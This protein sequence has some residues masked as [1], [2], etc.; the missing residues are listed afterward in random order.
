MHEMRPWADSVLEP[1]EVF[2]VRRWGAI[3]D[4]SSLIT[5]LLHTVRIHTSYKAR[6]NEYTPR[7][8]SQGLTKIQL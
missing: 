1:R 3:A 5:S 7:W 6:C 2:R 8:G 4:P